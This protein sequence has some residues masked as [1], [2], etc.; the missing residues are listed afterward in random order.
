MNTKTKMFIYLIKEGNKKITD[1][2]I[3]FLYES[4][5]TTEQFTDG[6]SNMNNKIGIFEL[7]VKAGDEKFTDEQI[8]F[9]VECFK[10]TVDLPDGLTQFLAGFFEKTE[11]PSAPKPDFKPIPNNDHTR[12]D[13]KHEKTGQP[14]APKPD[15]KPIPNNNHTHLDQKHGMF[16]GCVSYYVEDEETPIQWSFLRRK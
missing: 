7:V 9:L 6:M 16:D 2:Q 14:S 10:K 1:E 15:F 3:L 4:F 5:K 8:Q 11:Q 13:Q 12:Q